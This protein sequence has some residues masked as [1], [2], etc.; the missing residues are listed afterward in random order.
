M[1]RSK[2]IIITMFIIVF[3]VNVC[4]FYFLFFKIIIINKI[5]IYLIIFSL[6]SI[7]IITF[8]Q[9]NHLLKVFISLVLA[10]F[11]YN[12]FGFQYYEA[13]IGLQKKEMYFLT[14]NFSTQLPYH[15]KFL[16]INEKF[17]DDN[18]FIKNHLYFIKDGIIMEDG[19]D[20][21]KNQVLYYKTSRNEKI[22]IYRWIK[23]SEYGWYEN[24]K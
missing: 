12:L 14:N 23:K 6:I 21:I 5:I 7:L 1:K 3:L 17:I 15:S 18:I 8:S 9:K 20:Q 10:S 24:I 2:T 22:T 11:I 13:N 19:K 16:F 4:I